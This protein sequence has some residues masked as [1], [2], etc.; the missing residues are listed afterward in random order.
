[1][2]RNTSALIIFSIVLP[3]AFVPAA[4][5]GAM[6]PRSSAPYVTIRVQAT[7]QPV[8]RSRSKARDADHA[9]LRALADHVESQRLVVHAM[10]STPGSHASHG[11]AMDPA[12]WDGMFDGQQREALALLKHDYREELSPRTI[13]PTAPVTSVRD[14]AESVEQ[15]SMRSLIAMMREGVA[16]SDRFLPRLRRA[17]SRNLARRVRS[18]HMKLIRE[19]SA[20]SG[21]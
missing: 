11:T 16:L 17:S 8:P 2:Y 20:M 7:Q 5:V 14:D 18:S 9:Y 15:A 4:S 6:V 13:K 1:M 21:H 12:N 3:V 10:M 19:L